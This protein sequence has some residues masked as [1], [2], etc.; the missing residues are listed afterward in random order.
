MTLQVKI[1]DVEPCTV[2]KLGR[3]LLGDVRQHWDSACMLFLMACTSVRWRISE[4]ALR[5]E[6][7]R[8]LSRACCRERA[9]GNT[10]AETVTSR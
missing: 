1:K 3:K 10:A 6:M 8:A 2:I 4:L 5:P 7:T 9:N